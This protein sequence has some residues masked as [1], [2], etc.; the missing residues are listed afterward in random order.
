VTDLLPG[1]KDALAYQWTLY[2]APEAND[3]EAVYRLDHA[4]SWRDFRAALSL[5]GAIA[6]N[7]TYADRDGHIGMQTTGRV[8][9]RLG[10]PTGLGIRE[11]WDGSQDWAGF[12][13]FERMP[14]AYDPPEG[15]LATSNNLPFDK[16]V[17]FY[18]APRYEPPDRFQRVRERLSADTRWTPEKF[19]ALQNDVLWVT[20]RQW[21]P[22]VAPACTAD[23]L[24]RNAP[25]SDV[26]R[27]ALGLLAGW[28]GTMA[29]DAAAPALFAGLYRQWFAETF[30]DEFGG[31]L[32]RDLQQIDNLPANLLRVAIERDPAW[33]DRNGTPEREGVDAILCAAFR[34]AVAELSAAQGPA[35]EAWRWGA[36]HQLTLAHPLSR[37]KALAWYFSRGPYPRP[38][39]SQTVNKE[40]APWAEDAVKAGASTR[41]IVDLGD[42]AHAWSVLPGGQSGI[43]ASPRYN[44]QT[45]L[46]LSGATHPTWM[47]RADIERHVSERTQLV[48]ATAQPQ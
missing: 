46:W 47:E 9:L 43:P 4:E 2:A 12:I 39:S 32:L 28:N 42:P 29:A 33:F 21:A 19:G 7:V 26:E 34:K 30:A 16:S 11:G 44:D 15:W 17:G 36:K 20:A 38:G 45:A 13:A 3:V 31:P 22:R 48:P 8:P 40:Q 6:Q 5:M 25:L 10:T 14:S 18:L 24:A 41:Q 37:I 1:E 23:A 35:P 27:R